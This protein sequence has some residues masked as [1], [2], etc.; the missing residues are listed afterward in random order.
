MLKVSAYD[1]DYANPRKLRYGFSDETN[2]LDSSDKQAT[3]K[4][5]SYFKM[6]PDTGVI[7]VRKDVQVRT[8]ACKIS[9]ILAIYVYGF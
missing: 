4:I 6:N 2:H 1:G 7:S 5:S 9:F 8:I 3:S